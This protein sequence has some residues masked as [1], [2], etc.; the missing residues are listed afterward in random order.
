MGM[1]A[2]IARM[3][4]QQ[5]PA[6]SWAGAS[7][8]AIGIA[9]EGRSE[10]NVDPLE[11]MK[12]EQLARVAD[13]HVA[14]VLGLPTSTSGG[15]VTVVP[16]TRTRWVQDALEAYRPLVERLATALG[17]APDHDAEADAGDDPEAQ[18]AGML[19]SMMKMFQPMMLSMTAGSMVGHLATRALGVY[20]LPIPRPRSD[21]LQLV[22]PNLDAFGEAWSLP[23]DDLRLWMCVHEIA[24]HAVLGVPHVRARLDELLADFAAGFRSDP[25][26][27]EDRFASV[28]PTDPSS[29]A[30]LQEVF[31]D[32]EAILGA[33]RSPAQEALL[34]RLEATVA[35][36]VGVVDHVLDQIGAKL[37]PGYGMLTEALRRRRVEAGDAGRFVERLLGLELAQ[38]TY[39]RGEAFVEG[40]VERAGEDGLRQLWAGEAFLPTPAEVDAPGLWLARIELG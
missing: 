35:V 40:V 28:D 20:D 39:D 14:D 4:G 18:L 3:L 19:Q 6:G 9:T 36:V 26:A 23:P 7:Q 5:G 11:R 12:V 38:A 31:G 32:P 27:L 33:I 22:L 21:E 37:M 1:F 17:T 30:G 13:L 8:L 29:L 34:P 10:P 15:A 25:S 2:D 24:H 16:V